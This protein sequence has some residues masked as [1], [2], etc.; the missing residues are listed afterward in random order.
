MKKK[1]RIW[2]PILERSSKSRILEHW[3]TFLELRLLGLRKELSSHNISIYRISYWIESWIIYW[4]RWS[5]SW[6]MEILEAS[7]RLIF[8]NITWV[9]ISYVISLV[10]QFMHSPKADHL[11]VVH[12]ILRYLK[13]SIDWGILHKCHG[14]VN[15]EPHTDAS[16]VESM[17][18]SITE[19][20][21]LYDGWW[22]LGPLK[23]Q[24]KGSNFIQL[25]TGPWLIG[26]EFMVE[27]AIKRIGL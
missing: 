16:W 18:D 14:H 24:E 13:G 6:S 20:R 7:G 25:S 2:K 15:A 21:A 9:D 11:T 3:K 17:I 23:K 26:V 5:A 10:S 4:E 19:Y 22:K 8:L 12:R 1:L 27:D